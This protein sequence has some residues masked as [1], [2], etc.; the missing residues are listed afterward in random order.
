MPLMLLFSA[1]SQRYAIEARRV[2]EILPLLEARPIPHA[3]QGVIGIIDYRGETAPVVDLCVMLTGRPRRDW[4]N[5]RTIVLR[6]ENAGFL[7]MEAEQVNDTARFDEG[8]EQPSGVSCADA[9]Y[10]AGV[11]KDGAG[12]IQRVEIESLLTPAVR[13]SLY[14]RLVNEHGE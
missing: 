4:Y 12:L 6:L 7:A 14:R 13:E 3:P 11:L 1:G 5:S 10:L 8:A 9:P 2:V